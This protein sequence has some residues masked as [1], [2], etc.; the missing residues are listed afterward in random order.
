MK[1]SVLIVDDKVKICRSLAENFETIGYSC[2]IASDAATAL[3]IFEHRPPDVVVID[4]R[5]GTENGIDLLIRIKTERPGM[6]VVMMT[7]Y[8][9]I[10]C[11]VRSIKNGAF[12]Y[13]QKPIA[14]DKLSEV[15]G[16]AI[17][18]SKLDQGADAET[19]G[20]NPSTDQLVS[21]D[22]KLRAVLDKAAR[23]AKTDL[24]VLILGESGTGKELL[25]DFIHTG[26]VY[27]DREM[28]RVNCSAF[29]ESLLDSELFGYE[30][31]AFTGAESTFPGVFERANQST[32]FLDEVGDMPLTTQA[33]ILRIIQDRQFRRV[34]GREI[35]HTHFRLITATNRP[36]DTMIAAQE[37]REDLF[38][39]LNT[40]SLVLPALR[41]RKRDIPLLVD[42]IL[43]Q[44][45][46]EAQLPPIS[47]RPEVMEILTRHHWPGNIRELKNVIQYAAAITNSGQIG[48]SDLPPCLT[49]EQSTG[50]GCSDGQPSVRE[51][52][53]RD[54]IT[55]ALEQFGNNKSQTARYL[56]MT[57]KTLYDKIQK[58]RIS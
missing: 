30:K 2:D 16:N 46:K 4:V 14:F 42:H 39:R 34:G 19:D 1:R 21:R 12:D 36:L 5:L 35:H 15:V 3:R 17:E 31:G 44:S 13:V 18:L 29:Q 38:Y 43:E 23:V 57:R 33:K 20:T 25:A 32:L 24:P 49:A 56:G 8:A 10:P 54:L 45:R 41:D 47:V 51:Q 27:M 48:V 11:A 9:E 7:A 52:A 26:S 37:F 6:P 58:Y 40:V 22:P 28:I 55:S 50:E 53:E